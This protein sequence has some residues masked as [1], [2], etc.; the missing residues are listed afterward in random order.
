VSESE[1]IGDAFWF[2]FF[3]FKASY[4]MRREY[5]SVAGFKASKIGGV[6]KLLDNLCEKRDIKTLLSEVTLQLIFKRREL[7]PMFC[8]LTFLAVKT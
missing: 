2:C 8:L 7:K 1:H 4:R 3:F 6:T 5:A